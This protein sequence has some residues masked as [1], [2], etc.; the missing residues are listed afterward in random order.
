[1]K[2]VVAF[3]GIT[4]DGCPAFAVVGDKTDEEKLRDSNSGK[5]IETDRDNF[6]IFC[7]DC[8]IKSCIMEKGIDNCTKCSEYPCDKIK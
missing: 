2:K 8:E 7:S 6:Y 5:L 1:M 3:C 4:K